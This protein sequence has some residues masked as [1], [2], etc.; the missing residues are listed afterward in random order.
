MEQSGKKEKNCRSD[1]H[2]SFFSIDFYQEF[3]KRVESSTERK[4][5]KKLAS[6]T[7]VR[8]EQRKKI[9]SKINMQNWDDPSRLFVVN[10]RIRFFPCIFFEKMSTTNLSTEIDK[11]Q[12][13]PVNQETKVMQLERLNSTRKQSSFFSTVKKMKLSKNKYFLL[14]FLSFRFNEHKSWWKFSKQWIQSA[15]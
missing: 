10:I 6:L 9:C 1:R 2:F 8:F 5:L 3:C 11:T 7:L 12:R 4:L 14:L 15:K 13:A